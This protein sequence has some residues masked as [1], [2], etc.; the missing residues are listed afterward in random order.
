MR[1]ACVYAQRASIVE[2]VLLA[3]T[4]LDV[5][6]TRKGSRL[7]A[8]VEVGT[9]D[10]RPNK[11]SSAM[12]AFKSSDHDFSAVGQER[13]GSEGSVCSKLICAR[14]QLGPMNYRQ[15]WRNM[16]ERRVDYLGLPRL[17]T[18]NLPRHRSLRGLTPLQ[19]HDPSHY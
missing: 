11:N 17:S 14:A 6:T 18:K 4:M 9:A 8:L 5:I 7:A 19:S 10:T 2:G 3:S 13:M 16:N 15:H 1:A 12:G